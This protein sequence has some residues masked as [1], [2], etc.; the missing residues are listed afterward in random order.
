MK[1]TGEDTSIVV[2]SILFGLVF[3]LLSLSSLHTVNMVVDAVIYHPTVSHYLKY[4]AT[5]GT[6]FQTSSDCPIFAS[7]VLLHSR[8]EEFKGPL[9]CTGSQ[10]ISE[11]Y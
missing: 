7:F 10:W 2:F 3:A 1:T 5:T 6:S 9:T 4:V 11:T 8:L